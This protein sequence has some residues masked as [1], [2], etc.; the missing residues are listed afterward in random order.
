MNQ[1]IV[2]L[3][4]AGAVVSCASSG[5]AA[6]GPTGTSGTQTDGASGGEAGADSTLASKLTA[7]MATW[8]TVKPRCPRY[9]YS[10]IVSSVFGNCAVTT[11]EIADDQ[12]VRRSYIAQRPCDQQGQVI[13]QWDEVDASQVGTHR[14]PAALTVEQLFSECQD[15]LSSDP[16]TNTLSL[17]FNPQGVPDACIAR[18]INCQDDCDRG[19]RLGTFSCGD[20][21]DDGGVDAVAND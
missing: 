9:H 10:S 1:G 21:P 17:A 12:P 3:L 7:A 2:F 4:A 14:G 5:C 8:A 19:I 20:W 11:V 18:S 6:I 13:E 15:V 16:T